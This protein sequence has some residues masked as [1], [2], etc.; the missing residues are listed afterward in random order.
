METK[1]EPNKDAPPKYAS[2]AM[3]SYAVYLKQTAKEY[4]ARVRAFAQS[5]RRRSDKQP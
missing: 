5:Q 2:P 3:E 4:R 1:R